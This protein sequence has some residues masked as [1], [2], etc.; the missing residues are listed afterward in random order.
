MEWPIADHHGS[1]RGSADD[2]RGRRPEK[3]MMA[4]LGWPQILKSQKARVFAQGVLP[5]AG[6]R[7]VTGGVPESVPLTVAGLDTGTRS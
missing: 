7:L 5:A 3:T 1:R 6:I 4:D 2:Q